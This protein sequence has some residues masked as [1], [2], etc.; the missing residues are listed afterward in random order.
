MRGPASIRHVPQ[1]RARQAWAFRAFVSGSHGSEVRWRSRAPSARAAAR[2][3]RFPGTASQRKRPRLTAEEQ[4]GDSGLGLGRLDRS[5]DAG[6]T[7]GDAGYDWHKSSSDQKREWAHNATSASRA[8]LWGRDR[9]AIREIDDRG[10]DGPLVY[11]AII[12]ENGLL[13]E[14]SCR[15][16]DERTT[17]FGVENPG[18]DPLIFPFR[19]PCCPL[20]F[21]E[22]T[23]SQAACTICTAEHAVPDAARSSRDDDRSC[24]AVMSRTPSATL[25]R[26]S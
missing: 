8:V 1:P 12:V 7:R 19:G 24:N 18:L 22:H 2:C 26:A 14:Q 10:L 21:P 23:S 9:A 15:T 6:H 11:T 16:A 13:I 3:C 20:A 17:P 5:E 4:H 25:L